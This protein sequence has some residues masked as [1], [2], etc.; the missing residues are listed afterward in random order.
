MHPI[1]LDIPL[2]DRILEITSYRAAYTLAALMAVLVTW[3]IA[4]WRGVPGRRA[5]AVTIAAGLALPVGARLWHVV[6]NPSIYAEEPWRVWTLQPSGHALFGGVLMLAVVGYGA[7]RYVRVDPWIM[8]DAGAIGLGLGLAIQRVGCFAG[9]CCF[10]VPSDGPWGVLFPG[11]SP[12]HLWQMAHDLV[13]LFGEALPVHPTQL[14]ELT[15]ALVCSAIAWI[16]MWRRAPEGVAFAVFI[17][18]FSAVRWA[19]WQVRAHPD[20][21]TNPDVYTP[22][23][24]ATSVVCVGLAVWRWRVGKARSARSSDS[25]A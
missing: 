6:L 2:G 15:G 12:S 18:L 25:S 16:I 5:L 23:Y 9:G 3:A 20:T 11:G 21:L 14:Y 4:R 7:A 22:I 13:P 17:A 8:A 19:N 10:G 24:A 1:L